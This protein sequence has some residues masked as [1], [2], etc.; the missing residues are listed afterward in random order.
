[1]ILLLSTNIIFL[2]HLLTA[3]GTLCILLLSL[4]NILWLRASSYSPSSTDMGKV[5]VLIPARNEESNIRRCLE[6]LLHQ[7][8]T[9]YEIVVLDDLSTDSDLGNRFRIRSTLPGTPQ[10]R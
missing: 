8:Y 5:S 3:T 9:N 4:A 7:S 6:S 1:M 2:L 10:G